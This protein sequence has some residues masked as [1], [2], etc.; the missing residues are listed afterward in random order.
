MGTCKAGMEAWCTGKLMVEWGL[1]F[2]VSWYPHQLS[3]LMWYDDVDFDGVSILKNDVDGPMTSLSVWIM[4]MPT[5]KGRCLSVQKYCCLTDLD[6]YA[7]SGKGQNDTR[8]SKA[9]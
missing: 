3:W 8:M 4:V 2:V 7:E 9:S 1:R 5:R 6:C